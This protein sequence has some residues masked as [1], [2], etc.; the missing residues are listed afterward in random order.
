VDDF[1]MANCGCNDVSFELAWDGIRTGLHGYLKTTWP[2]EFLGTDIAL[3]RLGAEDA[4]DLSVD[5]TSGTGS[6]HVSCAKHID[7]ACARLLPS[8]PPI[9]TDPRVPMSVTHYTLMSR[10]ERLPLS[11]DDDGVAWYKQVIDS[12]TF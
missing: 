2:R 10:R 4:V 9:T 8:A 3:T 7:E 1:M 11:A 12:C 5:F 6:M